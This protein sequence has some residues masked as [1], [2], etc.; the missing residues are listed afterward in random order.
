MKKIITCLMAV[1][2]LAGC[3]S[4]PKA[5]SEDALKFKAEYEAL[6][7][8]KTDSGNEFLDMSISKSNEIVYADI[9][10][11]MEILDTEG[12]IYFGFPECPWCRN[13]VPVLLEAAAEE[14]VP[15]Y[16]FNAKPYRDDLSLDD[17]GK[18]VVNKEKDEEYQ[19]IYDKLYDSLPVYDGLND[20]TIKRL[21]FPSV[22]FVKDGKV[23]SF[24]EGTVSSQED[25]SIA[26]SKEQH[27]ELKAN[28]VK[29]FQDIKKAFCDIKC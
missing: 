20:E 16:Y 3:S 25:P 18:V 13:A 15:V 23:I 24:Q 11:V 6:N 8:T 21:Y 26:M 5:N 19:M 9:N 2:L 4:T 14:E 28:Y 17:A 22:V 12:V 1:L 27:D 7:G 29:S 10:K